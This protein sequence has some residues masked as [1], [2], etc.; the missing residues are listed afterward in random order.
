MI[1][2]AVILAGSNALMVAAALFL[3]HRYVSKRVNQARAAAVAELSKLIAGEPCQL[4]SIA[5]AL[6]AQIGAVAGRSA[7]A[8][9]MADLAHVK[10]DG[11]LDAADAAA[12][13]IA[14]QQPAL[15]GILAGMGSRSRKGL[16]SNPIAQL[17]LQGLLGNLGAPAAGNHQHSG[18]GDYTGRKHRE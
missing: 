8:S 12:G 14:T 5:N 15:G 13:A 1:V 2:A 10:R 16:L 6:G 11:A 9:L 4:G 17:A 7:K 18:S 3:V